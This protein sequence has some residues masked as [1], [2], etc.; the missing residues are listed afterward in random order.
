[1]QTEHKIS[2]ENLSTPVERVPERWLVIGPD[3]A[4]C[5]QARTLLNERASADEPSSFLAWRV[6]HGLLRVAPVTEVAHELSLALHEPTEP[7]VARSQARIWSTLTAEQWYANTKHCVVLSAP[8]ARSLEVRLLSEP[9]QQPLATSL[10]PIWDEAEQP[11]AMA[12]LMWLLNGRPLNVPRH[13]LALAPMPDRST[14]QNQAMADQGYRCFS[15]WASDMLEQHDADELKEAWGPFPEPTEV[16]QKESDEGEQVSAQSD[17]AVVS[18]VVPFRPKPNNLASKW[19]LPAGQQSYRLAADSASGQAISTSVHEWNDKRMLSKGVRVIQAH[20]VPP[21]RNSSTAEVPVQ[22]EFV[23][24]WD[25]KKDQPDD[26]ESLCLVVSLPKRKP[27][28]LHGLRLDNDPLRMRFVWPAQRRPADFPTRIFAA[29]TWLSHMLP[30][31]R[32][33]LQ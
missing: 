7:G 18:N 22:I 9:A 27:V 8:A 30:E 28:L 6:A 14:D 19:A 13:W 10:S 25:K 12:R 16:E 17:S 5:D 23:A 4:W 21:D 31:A 15:V 1:M 29:K 24:V 3:A 20:C 26:V 11:D 2:V 32:V 33:S